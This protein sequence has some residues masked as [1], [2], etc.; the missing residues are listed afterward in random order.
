MK[1]DDLET[2]LKNA[3]F[4]HLTEDELDSYHEQNLDDISRARAEAHLS[5]CLVCERRLALIK[6]ESAAL[7]EQ[8]IT[9]ED[10][11]LVRHVMQQLKPHETRSDAQA[12]TNPPLSDR[13]D[14]YLQQA[15]AS[16]R[17][18]F[19]QRATLRGSVDKVEVIWRWQSDDGV[20]KAHAIL[21]EN[22]NLTIHFSSTDTD[23]KCWRLKIS[24]GPLSRE[25]EFGRV[26]ESEVCAR[27][28]ISRQER[29]GDMTDISIEKA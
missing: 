3:R 16:W 1:L 17:A 20:F 13:L 15:T 12:E 9:D 11:A 18:H 2:A 5:L 8:R 19:M 7:A 10:V 24:I 27:I 29:P 6:E 14:E 21:E 22:A 4:Q 26:S 25:S 28:E 23:L